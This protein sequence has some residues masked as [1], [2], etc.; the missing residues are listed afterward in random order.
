MKMM[1]KKLK[2]HSAK[3]DLAKRE[4]TSSSYFRLLLKLSYATFTY[5]IMVHCYL[6][7]K[8]KFNSVSLSAP[9][10]VPCSEQL[11]HSRTAGT[12][13]IWKPRHPPVAD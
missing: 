4:D 5:I 1:E 13:W 12:I 10:T 7:Y 3:R 11:A 9:P 2:W 8:P 6:Y